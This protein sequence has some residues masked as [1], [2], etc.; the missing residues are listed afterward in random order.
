MTILSVC[1]AVFTPLALFVPMRRIWELNAGELIERY[2]AAVAVP[3]L[4]DQSPNPQTD[5]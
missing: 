4:E 1:R 5:D 3:H 2:K